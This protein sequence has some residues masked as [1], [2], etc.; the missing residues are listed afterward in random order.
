MTIWPNPKH[1]SSLVQIDF[2]FLEKHLK[3]HQ[4]NVTGS[5]H[6]FIRATMLI[7]IILFK[8]QVQTS[9]DLIHDRQNSTEE[10]VLQ[11]NRSSSYLSVSLSVGASE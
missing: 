5:T 2:Y 8:L 7:I 10:G 4:M 1:V 11:Y 6:P 9:T 3:S